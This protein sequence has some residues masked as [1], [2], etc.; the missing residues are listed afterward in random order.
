M[1]NQPQKVNSSRQQQPPTDIE[2]LGVAPLEDT[3]GEENRF[4]DVRQL[5]PPLPMPEHSSSQQDMRIP[6]PIPQTDE[7]LKLFNENQN[8]PPSREYLMGNHL[9]RWKKIRQKWKD[10]AASNEQRYKESLSI[11]KA[12]FER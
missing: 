7:P 4:K 9:V 8:P 2:L 11:I 12:I 3:K 6:S 5:P 1:F 10:A